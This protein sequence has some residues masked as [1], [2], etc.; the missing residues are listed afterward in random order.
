M[1]ARRAY[2]RAFAASPGDPDIAALLAD[3]LEKENR[4]EDARRMVETTLASQPEH[5]LGNMIM[6]ILERRAGRAGEAR[7]RLLAMPDSSLPVR[8]QV[9][10]EHELGVLHDLA[11]EYDSAY[12]CLARANVTNELHHARTSRY[13]TE[14]S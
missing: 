3:C 14:H 4:L 1:E 8:L 13:P 6:A 2:E 9:Q 5:H 11:D 10:R 7:A 12:A